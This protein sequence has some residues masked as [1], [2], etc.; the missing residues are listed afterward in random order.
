[1]SFVH[2]AKNSTVTG[3]AQSV[4][5]IFLYGFGFWVMIAAALMTWFAV[6]VAC[7]AHVCPTLGV[8]HT[9]SERT[10]DHKLLLGF[11][12]DVIVYDEHH[13]VVVQ[14]VLAAC[15]GQCVTCSC[16]LEN[17]PRWPSAQYTN[18]NGSLML[19]I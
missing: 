19:E 13:L 5:V 1:M 10:A 11:W 18:A 3:T 6:R 4:A 16:K 14:N 17:G 2:G 7:S 15:A 12:W 8:C 9:S